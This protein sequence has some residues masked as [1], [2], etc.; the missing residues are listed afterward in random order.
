MMSNQSMQIGTVLLIAGLLVTG[1][2]SELEVESSDASDLRAQ[3]AEIDEFEEPFQLAIDQRVG[4]T[5]DQIRDAVFTA[6]TG[7]VRGCLGEAGYDVVAER[8]QEIVAHDMFEAASLLEV[9]LEQ[10][11]DGDPWDDVGAPPDQIV[12]CLEHAEAAINPQYELARLLQGATT[13]ISRR[14]ANH[15]ELIMATRWERAC[16]AKSS[17]SDYGVASL[18]EEDKAVA[19]V[20]AAVHGEELSVEEGKRA[21]RSLVDKRAGLDVALAEVEV[22]VGH[23]LQVERKLVAEQQRQWLTANPGWIDDVAS[24]YV[25]ILQPLVRGL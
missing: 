2:G 23:R 18:V 14:L 6:R 24:R 10:L 1:C 25:V 20:M 17:F 16:V 5:V 22:C 15:P 13:T 19:D 21:L 9:S 3:S 11:D 8:V 12:K 4:L 7:A